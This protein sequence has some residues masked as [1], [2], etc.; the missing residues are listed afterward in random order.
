MPENKMKILLLEDNPA[1]AGLIKTLLERAGILSEFAVAADKSEF[2]EAITKN[3][4]DVILADH[5]LPQFSS[6][7][8]L[9]IIKDK[10]MDVIF[11]LVTGTVSEEFAVSIIQQGADDYL[12]KNNLNRLPAAII[13][14]IE[15]RKMQLAK[16]LAEEELKTSREQLR[17]LFFHTQNIRE[18]ERARIAREIHDELGQQLTGLKMDV[19][20]LNKKLNPVDAEV[21][22]KIAGMIG[23][24]DSTVRSVRKISSDL[25]PGI[26]DD[27]GLI[28][29]LD[30]QSSEFEKRTE[31]ECKFHSETNE[32]NFE[33]DLA[34][35][36]FRIFQETLTNVARHAQAT[37]IN[38]MLE[39]DNEMIVLTINDNGKGFDQKQ[40]P[41]KNT[42]GIIGMGE[43]AMMMGGELKINST[44]GKGTTTI[45]KVPLRIETT[46]LK[47]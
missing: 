35:N 10:N 27:L 40:I 2:I 13:Q 43:R 11:I 36:I 19:F 1:D 46:P 32:Q 5:R 39:Q 21:K 7:E 42:L 34:T 14:S 29:A 8:A 22:E 30:W 15:R 3:S 25:R 18:E 26:L 16:K 38:S 37:K 24:I 12:L 4:F 9:K 23:L 33:K 28:A 45:L 31:I 47:N 20:W 6:V 44:P 17:Q 41:K